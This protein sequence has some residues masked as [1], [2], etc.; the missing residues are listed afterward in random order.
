M[1]K[2]LKSLAILL[3]LILT[4]GVVPESA[5]AASDPVLSMADDKILYL[6]GSKGVRES[7]GSTC[8]VSYKKK[9]TNMIIG[10]D[11]DKMSVSLKSSD[12]DIVRI[13]KKEYIVAESVGKA[14][15]TVTVYNANKKKIFKHDLL[16]NVKRNAD[17]VLY[18]GIRDNDVVRVGQTFEISLPTNDKDTDRRELLAD[19]PELVEITPMEATNTWSVKFLT[20]GD[21]TFTGRAYQSSIYTGTTAQVQFKASIK[22]LKLTDA[23]AVAPNAIKMT[24]NMNIK[25]SNY[26]T[27]VDYDNSCYYM[28][29]GRKVYF[30]F[31]TSQKVS[32]ENM[33]I[34]LNDS[35][36][37]GKT[38]YVEFKGSD[39]IAI[40]IPKEEED[41]EPE[42]FVPS[43]PAAPYPATIEVTASQ[44][45][46][47]FDVNENERK[48][49][50][51]F[52]AE[53]M[54]QYGNYFDVGAQNLTWSQDT[55]STSSFTINPGLSFTQTNVGK[56]ELIITPQSFTSS[57]GSEATVTLTTTVTGY[58]S[59]S[60][61]TRFSIK[62]AGSTQNSSDTVAFINAG[63]ST[64]DVAIKD[65]TYRERASIRLC[66]YNT[67]GYY[68]GDVKF[69][70]LDAEPVKSN[71]VS[72]ESAIKYALVIKKDGAVITAND[73]T[74]L[75]YLE[76]IAGQDGFYDHADLYNFSDL[77]SA[78]VQAATGTYTFTLY[79]I[80]PAEQ[81]VKVTIS[82]Y[83]SKSVRVVNN[84]VAPTYT[85][86]S[87]RTTAANA[88]NK[89]FTDCFTFSFA[90]RTYQQGVTYEVSD[91]YNIGGT[92][93]T[94][95][96]TKANV[97]VEFSYVDGSY[98]QGSEQKTCNVPCT[99]N[100][101]IYKSA[102]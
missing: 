20:P 99:I 41:E 59:L 15:V 102:P 32:G 58:P 37:P 33:W 22:E 12:T 10:Y 8:S 86:I 23:E 70:L 76:A 63:E 17:R 19:K 84:Q 36:T 47:N 85:V 27:E 89:N 97:P 14:T 90:G 3:A 98:G 69:A 60:R 13:S 66:S 29:N 78:F 53:V 55:T 7:D 56:Y 77:N 94:V 25:R 75:S 82:E 61:S 62:K 74:S 30:S 43:A 34:Y 64:L 26:Y 38:Y 92:S 16:V 87:T 50:I 24:F 9:V 96:V 45:K 42:P 88:S 95:K 73:V 11:F 67:E 4:V 6:D 44:D 52:K 39:P 5:N 57:P 100:I 51:T 72:S 79:A 46:L 91:S 71:Y 35:F 21:V 68:T 93:D 18:E 83:A 65:T 1:R 2:F 49:A 81:E 31:S 101:F 54:D 28:D 48:D 40:S 80:T